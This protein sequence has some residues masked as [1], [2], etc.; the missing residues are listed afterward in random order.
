MN[1]SDRERAPLFD[2]G[3]AATASCLLKQTEHAPDHGGTGGQQS[4]VRGRLFSRSTVSGS[5]DRVPHPSHWSDGAS[6]TVVLLLSLGV[7]AT[8][9]R[10]IASLA[11]ASLL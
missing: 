4:F 6:L 1:T 8:I 3:K 9:W 10:A 11:S 5:M 7:W 2:T